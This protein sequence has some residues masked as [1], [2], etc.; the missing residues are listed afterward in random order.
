MRAARSAGMKV[1]LD[2][3]GGDEVLAGYPTTFSYLLA[4]MLAAGRLVA[5][6]RARSRRIAAS[7]ADLAAPL[8]RP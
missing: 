5:T 8:L 7:R 1:M 6:R 2:G 4:D 3:Q